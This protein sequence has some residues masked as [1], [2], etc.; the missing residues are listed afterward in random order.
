VHLQ[1]VA[2]LGEVLAIALDLGILGDAHG[3]ILQHGNTVVRSKWVYV[4]G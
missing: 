1:L 4:L 3:R 2:R